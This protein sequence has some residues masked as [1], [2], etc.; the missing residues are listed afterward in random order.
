MSGKKNSA[1]QLQPFVPLIKETLASRAGRA[2]SHGA[3]SLYVALKARYSS[4]LHNNGRIF[5]SQRVASHEVGSSFEQIAR[6]FRELQYYGFIVQTQGG[7]LGLDGKG[8]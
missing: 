7:S 1:E 8:T 5:I 3:R 2:M 4:T 6:W